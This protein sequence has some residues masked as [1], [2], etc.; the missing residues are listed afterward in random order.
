MYAQQTYAA[1]QAIPKS[2]TEDSKI[3]V[4]NY[5]IPCMHNNIPF[6]HHKDMINTELDKCTT[7]I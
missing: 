2:K 1:I 4:N 3:Q 6:M 5:H 7:K